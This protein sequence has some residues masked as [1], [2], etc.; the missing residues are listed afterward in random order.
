MERRG[1]V[2]HPSRVG[3]A[4]STVSKPSEPSRTRAVTTP[5]DSVTFVPSYWTRCSPGVPP[6]VLYVEGTG[7]VSVPTGLERWMWKHRFQ[8]GRIIEEW[9]WLSCS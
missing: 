6:D 7:R 9:G 8:S 4:P 1:T 2:C 3:V 5:V